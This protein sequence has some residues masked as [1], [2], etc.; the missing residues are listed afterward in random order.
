[1]LSRRRGESTEQRL[2][3]SSRSLKPSAPLPCMTLWD[4]HTHAEDFLS[5]S[6]RPCHTRQELIKQIQQSRDSCDID[7]ALRLCTHTRS[8]INRLCGMDDSVKHFFQK[9][10]FASFCMFFLFSVFPCSFRLFF[11]P[12]LFFSLFYFS[13]VF[14]FSCFTFFLLYV[15]V[16]FY[17]VFPRCPFFL[18]VISCLCFTVFYFLFVSSCF[19]ILFLLVCCSFF[20]VVVLVF[21][22]FSLIFLFFLVLLLFFSLFFSSFLL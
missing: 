9:K 15:L 17:F 10:L 7:S 6:Q 1:M 13:I 18:I 22:G 2:R 14:L 3:N 20:Y 21:L 4:L 19:F 8:I 12:L 16:C 5:L 11:C